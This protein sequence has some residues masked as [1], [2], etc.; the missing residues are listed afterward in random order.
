MTERSGGEA[1]ATYAIVIFM[2]RGDDGRVKL[3]FMGILFPPLE[4]QPCIFLL[5][6]GDLKPSF[7]FSFLYFGTPEEA[8][9][10]CF[11]LF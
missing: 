9:I 4:P 5:V 7:C 10:F 3:Q 1:F 11:W 6:V 2:V 8:S